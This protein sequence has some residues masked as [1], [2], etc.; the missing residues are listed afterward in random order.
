MKARLFG[1]HAD[2]W[3]VK[4]DQPDDPKCFSEELRAV[5][6]PENFEG[7]DNFFIDV[8]TPEWIKERHY[9]LKWGRFM[10]IVDR[11][12]YEEIYKFLEQYVSSFE[13]DSWNKLA[14][15]LS[16]VMSWEF[17]DYVNFSGGRN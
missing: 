5:I 3:D 4:K 15:K 1:L 8:C 16:R 9:G 6:G 2:T 14:I 11:Y 13:E 17:E 12:S 7:G 10:L